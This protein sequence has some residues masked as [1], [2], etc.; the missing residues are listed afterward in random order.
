MSEDQA[1]YI[2]DALEMMGAGY[3]KAAII[4]RPRKTHAIGDAG[5]EEYQLFG[6]VKMSAKFCAHIK[7]LRGA[8]LSIWLCLSLNIDEDGECRL[9]QKELCAMTGYSHTEVIDSVTELNEM[10]FLSVDRSGKKNLYKPVFV[11]KGKG[12]NPLV[13]KLDSTPADSLESSPSYI[14][15]V[16]TS[17]KKK[18]EYTLTESDYEQ[19]NT[20][21]NA[22]I[23]GSIDPQILR[24][25]QAIDAFESAFGVE[26][27]WN[28]YPAKTSEE[29]TWRDFRAYVV[30]KYEADPQCFTRYVTWRNQKYSKGTM[31]NLAIKRNPQDF[32]DSWV[33]FL[34]SDS[35]YGKEPVAP[36]YK[37][38]PE[39]TNV[40]VPNPHRRTG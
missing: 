25:K 37:P 23:A 31:S 2:T 22:I 21:V 15:S 12:K 24:E 13:K 7:K 10:G 39:D 11:A 17:I 19:V 36:I 29:K 33:M 30:E 32:P 4:E 16:P 20:T 27:P 18:K 6:W 8:K 35:M 1:E 26:R 9:T 34:A 38:L 40:Y 5:L 14:N 28:W 3:D